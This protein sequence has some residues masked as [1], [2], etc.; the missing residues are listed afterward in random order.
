[1][2][3]FWK[4]YFPDNALDLISAQ[5]TFL[6]FQNHLLNVEYVDDK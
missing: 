5:K 4:R 1:M 3:G 2:S 6:F